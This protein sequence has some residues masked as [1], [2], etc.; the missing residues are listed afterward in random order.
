MSGNQL[1][2][3]GG[4]DQG[5]TEGSGREPDDR[6]DKVLE[7]QFGGARS[8]KREKECGDFQLG[9]AQAF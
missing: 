5:G 6:G 8:A 3:F 9:G 1:G 4:L 2:G 7:V